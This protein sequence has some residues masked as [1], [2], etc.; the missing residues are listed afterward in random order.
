MIKNISKAVF[1]TAFLINIGCV[2]QSDY[3]FVFTCN[4]EGKK[5]NAKMA[6]W[7]LNIIEAMSNGNVFLIELYDEEG[8]PN[9]VP[10][11]KTYGLISNEGSSS[12]MFGCSS[13]S[14]DVFCDDEGQ[15]YSRSGQLL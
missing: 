11:E 1:I 12:I 6:V 4:I 8:C 7:S 3:D 9:F 5:F 14:K 13:Q 10:E 2:P 15:Y